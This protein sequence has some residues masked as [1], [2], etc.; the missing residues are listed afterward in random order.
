MIYVSDA[1]K[2][3]IRLESKT[4]ASLVQ[5]VLAKNLEL[6]AAGSYDDEP[7]EEHYAYP[8]DQGYPT[9]KG[10]RKTLDEKGE[11]VLAVPRKLSLDLFVLP[12]KS[13]P[14]DPQESIKTRKLCSKALMDEVVAIEKNGFLGE[15]ESDIGDADGDADA[16]ADAD[17]D[18]DG[19]AVVKIDAAANRDGTAICSASSSLPHLLAA[20]AGRW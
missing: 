2:D 7:K 15:N 10:W 4:Y 17:G 12:S 1:K 6:K 11:I 20:L 13:S 3:S 5:D 8:N 9:I 16:D 19:D 18:G 14:Y